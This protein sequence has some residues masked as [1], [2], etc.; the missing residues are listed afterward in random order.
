MR[1]STP[2]LATLPAQR[3]ACKNEPWFVFEAH[4]NPLTG[5]LSANRGVSSTIAMLCPIGG[6]CQDDPGTNPPHRSATHAKQT[7][8]RLL[9][10]L[11][12]AAVGSSD[13]LKHV[14]VRILEVDAASAI[15]AVD[16]A[17]AL[18]NGV[19]PILDPALADAA[20]DLVEIVLSR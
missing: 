19:S 6:R 3:R 2:Y 7:E 1:V 14:A 10:R 4:E 11:C 17:A 12:G 13:D 15:I 8:F 18:L 20:E 9:L 5:G 16:L